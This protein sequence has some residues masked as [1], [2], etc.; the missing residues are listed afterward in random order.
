MV[1][2]VEHDHFIG[3]ARILQGARHLLALLEIDDRIVLAVDQQ[4]RRI[5]L[6]GEAARGDVVSS[7]R[8]PSSSASDRRNILLLPLSPIIASDTSVG[9]R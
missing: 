1:L 5:G 9:G 3:F 8:G 2:M 6:V 7:A 4:D